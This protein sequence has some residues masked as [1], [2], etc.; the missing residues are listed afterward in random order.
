MTY[1]AGKPVYTKLQTW[2]IY[3]FAQKLYLQIIP[4]WHLDLITANA[5]VQQHED[6][7]KHSSPWCE[8]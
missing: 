1:N 8:Y 4:S 3:L 7:Y 6:E 2:N 5:R